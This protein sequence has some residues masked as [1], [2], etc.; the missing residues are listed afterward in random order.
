LSEEALEKLLDWKIHINK[1]I[2]NNILDKGK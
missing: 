1:Y 2:V